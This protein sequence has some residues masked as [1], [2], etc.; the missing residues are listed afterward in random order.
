PFEEQAAREQLCTMYE[1]E[2]LLVIDKPAPMTVHPTA[3]HYKHTVIKRLEA[4]RPGEFLS[5]VHRL[6]RETSGA[7]LIARSPQAD[8]RFKRCLEDRSLQFAL[9]QTPRA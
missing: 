4:Q 6:D 7:L 5:L 3:R 2:H 1:D 8:R 9:A